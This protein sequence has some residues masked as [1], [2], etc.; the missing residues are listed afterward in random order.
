MPCTF[1]GVLNE[2]NFNPS[3]PAH[4]PAVSDSTVCKYCYWRW[5]IHS[6]PSLVRDCC[7]IIRGLQ[8]INHTMKIGGSSHWAHSIAW[9]PAHALFPDK[10]TRHVSR[11][12]DPTL[13][14]TTRKAN[15]STPHRLTWT[16]L[17]HR[18]QTGRHW[19]CFKGLDSPQG[20]NMACSSSNWRKLRS[21]KQERKQLSSWNPS[22]IEEW[23]YS[24]CEKIELY[25]II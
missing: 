15:H 11:S 14:R 24:K 20:I 23:A 18:K 1:C 6:S 2:S 17:A 5:S 13:K 22:T 25:S 21:G 9:C 8:S 19:K 3:Q 4:S 10:A 12:I 16:Q 7:L